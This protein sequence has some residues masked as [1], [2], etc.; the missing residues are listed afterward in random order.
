MSKYLHLSLTTES[1]SSLSEKMQPVEPPEV[2]SEPLNI[3]QPSKSESIQSELKELKYENKVLK[4][5]VLKISAS[6]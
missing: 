6:L 4:Q 5:L 1:C 3:D 2:S